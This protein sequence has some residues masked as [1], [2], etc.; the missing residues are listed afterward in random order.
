MAHRR[1]IAL[2]R[3]RRNPEVPGSIPKAR[4]CVSPFPQGL[5]PLQKTRPKGFSAAKMLFG[6]GKQRF[7]VPTQGLFLAPKARS[8]FFC[9]AA[10]LLFWLRKQRAAGAGGTA[11]PDAGE[12]VPRPTPKVPIY[13]K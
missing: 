5:F 3:G 7:S 10:E 2:A 13:R 4:E 9:S 12:P 1:Q 6:L 8:S 11:S